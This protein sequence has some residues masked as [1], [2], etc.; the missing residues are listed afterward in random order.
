[1]ATCMAVGNAV[2]VDRTVARGCGGGC[3]ISGMCPSCS[4]P[5]LAR[6]AAI[7]SSRS[8]QALASHTKRPSQPLPL[9]LSLCRCCGRCSSAPIALIAASAS[10]RS[11]CALTVPDATVVSIHTSKPPLAPAD[12]APLTAA[13]TRRRARLRRGDRRD[14]RRLLDSTLRCNREAEGGRRDGAGSRWARLDGSS[15]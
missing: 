11:Q 13:V 15:D 7:T 3:H 2:A 8:R 6:D 1:M 4:L 12:S 5:S 14:T 9:M 10:A